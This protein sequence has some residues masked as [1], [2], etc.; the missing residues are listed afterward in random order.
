MRTFI[1]QS[2]MWKVASY[3]DKITLREIR[4]TTSDLSFPGTFAYKDQLNLRMV[5]PD[6]GFYILIGE[7]FK[8]GKAAS[9]IGPYRFKRRI[10][11]FHRAKT[12]N[13]ICK[14]NK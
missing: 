2:A 4:D 3:Q 7:K 5:M 13:F 8:A 14:I 9:Y 1:G 12:N 6:M 11:M 10:Y